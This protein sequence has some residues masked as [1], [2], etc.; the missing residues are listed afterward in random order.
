MAVL[1]GGD[2]ISLVGMAIERKHA[3]EINYNK[4][5]LIN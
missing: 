5:Q 4:N 1:V 3:L 2:L